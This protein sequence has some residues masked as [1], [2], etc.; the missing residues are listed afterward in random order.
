MKFSKVGLAITILALAGCSS[1]P[2][3]KGEIPTISSQSFNTKVPGETIKI[4]KSCGW[5]QRS[6]CQIEGIEAVGIQPSVGA[7]R[8]LQKSA[9]EMACMNAQANVASYIF[10]INVSDDRNSRV[11]N[12][13]NENQKDRVKSRTEI[14]QD[15]D[16]SPDDPSK[17]TNFSVREALINTDIDNVRTVTTNVR[18]HLIGFHI[19]E[20]K[21]VDSKTMSCTIVWSRKDTQDMRSVRQLMLNNK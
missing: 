1:T 5:L 6:K 12:R 13:Q 11:R 18:G 2:V 17:D 7:T 9:T 21:V 16:L 15:V 4:E 8:L 14:G 19:K 10:G 3:G 20:T